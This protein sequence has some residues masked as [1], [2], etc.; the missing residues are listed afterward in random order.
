MTIL[1]GTWAIQRLKLG[2]EQWFISLIF[3]YLK[4][5]AMLLWVYS[6]HTQ[7]HGEPRTMSVHKQNY[8][9]LFLQF[10]PLCYFP[11]TF[12]RD[13]FSGSSGQD[14]VLSEFYPLCCEVPH[15]WSSH[16]ATRAKEKNNGESPQTLQKPQT[17]F[18]ASSGQREVTKWVYHANV[19]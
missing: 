16:L 17:P 6:K 1:P 2:L 11:Y 10:S 19:I 4:V 8:R 5:W 12:P 14:E 9:L 7:L 3:Q 13:P 18:P 15:K